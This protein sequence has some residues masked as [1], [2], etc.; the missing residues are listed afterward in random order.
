[1]HAIEYLLFENP[2]ERIGEIV[3]DKL[4]EEDEQR[5]DRGVVPLPPAARER[6][7][8]RGHAEADHAGVGE[9]AAVSPA[10]AEGGEA[11]CI[12]GSNE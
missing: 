10:A 6:G 11:V 8:G 12:V 7:Q 3:V 2:R 9:G 5:V 1:M 4:P